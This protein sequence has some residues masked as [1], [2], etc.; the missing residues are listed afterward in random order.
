[1]HAI[2]TQDKVEKGLAVT[3]C[4]AAPLGV[5]ENMFVLLIVDRPRNTNTTK[6]KARTDFIPI[7]VLNAGLNMYFFIFLALKSFSGKNEKRI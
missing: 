5:L 3:S 2:M 4:T 7:L 1:M 6:T